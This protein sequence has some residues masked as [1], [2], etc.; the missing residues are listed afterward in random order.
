MVFR[1]GFLFLQNRYARVA[2]L[3]ICKTGL[4]NLREYISAAYFG[5]FSIRVYH[6]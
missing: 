6:P 2:M 5:L 1:E 4:Q 3:H